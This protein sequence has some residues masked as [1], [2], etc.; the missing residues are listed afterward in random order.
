VL[1]DEAVEKTITLSFH[2]RRPTVR[3]IEPVV[4]AEGTSIQFAGARRLFIRTPKRTFIVDLL[5]GAAEFSTDRE[6]PMYRFPFPAMQATP[7]VILVPPPSTGTIQ[8]LRYRIAVEGRSASDV[9]RD[10]YFTMSTALER[11]KR[12][13]PL[14]RIPSQAGRS[15][16]VTAQGLVYVKR[17]T[18]PLH[19]DLCRPASAR[20]ALPAV[21]IIHGGGWRSGDRSMEVPMAQ[22]F[23]RNGYV[24]A[25]VEYRLSAEARY[26]AAL[27]DCRDALRWLRANAS[28]YSIDTNRIAVL[29][30]SSGGH[31]AALLAT[32][33][34][35][36]SC[37]GPRVRAVV[38]FDGPVDL[39]A[40]EESGKDE[41]PARPSSA[42]LWLGFTY[43]ERPELWRNVSPAFL[44]NEHAPP[45][46]FVNSSQ[47][48]Y[49][50]GRDRMISRMKEFG[51]ESAVV[52]I[53]D[54]PH[55]FWLLDPWSEQAF[56]AARTF[57]DRQLKT[58]GR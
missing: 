52:E 50:A 4:T 17:G 47:P 7:I 28:R 30:G 3:V 57:L 11:A 51:I 41:D 9:P 25:V 31:L 56:D 35:A 38:D 18:R 22:R 54:S 55:T 13:H 40:P 8:T 58:G 37:S 53:P 12:T 15:G 23:A 39:T 42:K 2:D 29:G 36:D 10:T 43:A 44:V 26:P 24:A 33:G 6:F 19:L 34:E 32:S 16:L 21:L 27:S 48:R 46:L 14:A 5:D 1:F 45:V 49:R 20:G